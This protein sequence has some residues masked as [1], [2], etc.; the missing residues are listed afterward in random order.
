[1]KQKGLITGATEARSTVSDPNARAVSK[2]LPLK[3][4]V[5]MQG[6]VQLN[7]TMMLRK[8]ISE[9]K[10]LRVKKKTKLR[11]QLGLLLTLWNTYWR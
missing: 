5:I 1:L 10:F 3:K 11:L 8:S 4:K 9:A 6:D 2:P 7:R